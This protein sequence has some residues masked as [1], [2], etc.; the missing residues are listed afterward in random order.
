[1]TKSIYAIGDCPVC[2]GSSYAIVLVSEN[3]LVF[4][5]PLCEVA[6]DKLPLELNGSNVLTLPE[7][8]PNGVSLPDDELLSNSRVRAFVV[9]DA[10]CC[11]E[12]LKHIT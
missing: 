12:V 1:M 6:W 7:V 3:N 4:F 5:C 10:W 9:T 11:E 2:P 8:A